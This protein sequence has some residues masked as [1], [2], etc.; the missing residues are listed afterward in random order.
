MQNEIKLIMC[1]AEQLMHQLDKV[2]SCRGN[3][4]RHRKSQNIIVRISKIIMSFFLL[5]I[6]KIIMLIKEILDKIEW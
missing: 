4:K 5:L 6:R 3:K 2:D 1:K